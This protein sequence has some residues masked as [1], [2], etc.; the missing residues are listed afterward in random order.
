MTPP[1]VCGGNSLVCCHV[2]ADSISARA[3]RVTTNPRGRDKFLPCDTPKTY[4]LILQYSR[5]FCKDFCVNI[6]YG[7][8]GFCTVCVGGGTFDAVPAQRAGAV[9][10]GGAA[11]GQILGVLLL[12]ILLALVA[13]LSLG[14][15]PL[16]HLGVNR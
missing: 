13:V 11:A 6:L 9:L 4:L 3:V 2:G 8:H 15:E 1:G 10:G 12:D 16:G 5:Q 14:D 7:A